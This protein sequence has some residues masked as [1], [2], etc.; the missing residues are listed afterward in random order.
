MTCKIKIKIS[1][2]D[3]VRDSPEECLLR[4]VDTIKDCQSRMKN[5]LE[6]VNVQVSMHNN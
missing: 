1:G 6:R 2:I 3:L 5:L 4:E